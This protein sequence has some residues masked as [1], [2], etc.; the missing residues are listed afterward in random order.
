MKTNEEQVKWR[1]TRNKKY[2]DEEW[3]RRTKKNI[4]EEEDDEEY[5]KEEEE[6]KKIWKTSKSM[7]SGEQD[8]W[9]WMKTNE[10]QVKWRRIRNKKNEDEEWKRIMNKKNE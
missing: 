2:K 8:E 4:V 9:R 10:E 6:I 7:N 3:I 1:R 5:E